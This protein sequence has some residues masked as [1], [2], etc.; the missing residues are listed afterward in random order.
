MVDVVAAASFAP[1]VVVVVRGTEVVWEA[2]G[3]SRILGKNY[4]IGSRRL[5]FITFISRAD[6]IW[7]IFTTPYSSP[8]L[9]RRSA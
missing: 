7:R 8:S 5:E 6:G 9:W 1:V 4:I 3:N 2:Q